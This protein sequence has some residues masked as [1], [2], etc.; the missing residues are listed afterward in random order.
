MALLA[1][2]LCLVFIAWLL[3]RDSKRHP[4]VSAVLW[5]PTLMALI[6]GSRSPSQW[7]SLSPVGQ[8]SPGSAA[9]NLSDQAFFLLMMIGSWI[10]ASSRGVKWYKLFA[11]NAAIML[12]YLYFVVGCS[13]SDHPG[14]S[15]IRIL[16][17]F[18]A[19]VV[20]I[21]VILSEKNPQEAIRTVYT[22]CA[23]VLIPLSAFFMKF[24]YH[25]FGRSYGKNGD[26]MFTGVAVQKN[27]LGELMLV[28]SFFLIWDHLET[29][30]AGAKRL[31]GTIRWD[32]LVLLF[33]GAW[34]LNASQSKS[35]LVCLLIGVAVMVSGWLDSRKI[36]RIVFFVVLSLPFLLLL[37]QQF[38]S[39]LGPVLGLLGRDATFT[40]RT[41]IWK[42]IGLTTV[43]PLVGAGFY[44]FWGG[45]GGEAIRVAM[46][47]EVPNAHDGYLDL[48]LDGGIIG[49]ILLFCVLW[50]SGR[51]IIANLGKNRYQRVRFA[52][53]IVAIVSNLTESSFARPSLL[54]F[55]MILVILEFPFLKV[56][57]TAG[58]G[59]PKRNSS[60]SVMAVAR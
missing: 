28:C 53:L 13:W 50:T 38:S 24:T 57:E 36:S 37:T 42:H 55:T 6:L 22:R 33:M 17:D 12:F 20:V 31:W 5:M 59:L 58:H 46:Q 25:G 1:L 4:S 19:T 39:A 7:L 35:S 34:I 2:F 54:W 45:K 40:G 47:T 15:F 27:S 56:N 41:D 30:P 3:V 51:R 48:F 32:Y 14:D 16:K 11:A 18:G 10:V 23:C 43:N 21:S 29:R 9:G 60:N 8:D 44:N 52:F 49:L 26:V